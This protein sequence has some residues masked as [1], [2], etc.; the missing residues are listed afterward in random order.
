MSFFGVLAN[1]SGPAIAPDPA[2]RTV[3]SMGDVLLQIT[4]DNTW[5]QPPTVVDSDP[6]P[7]PHS[8]HAVAYLL[9]TRADLEPL[10]V[11]EAEARLADLGHH[12]PR[13]YTD[14]RIVSPGLRSALLR[15]WNL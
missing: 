6:I 4:T 9:R 12:N 10:P 13:L 15:L 7:I 14:H 8:P 1:T 3:G 2:S 11:P 5:I